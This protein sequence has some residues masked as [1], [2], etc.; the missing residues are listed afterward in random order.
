[1]FGWKIF[2]YALMKNHFH[3]VL[4]TVNPNLVEGM[5]WLQCTYCTRFNR[6]RSERGHVFQGRYYAGLIENAAVMSHI[7]DYVHLN[8]VRAEIVDADNAA[9]FRWSSLGRFVRG[10]RFPGLVANE[11]LEAKGLV[12][13]DNGWA[14][15]QTELKELAENLDKQKE[16]G[17]DGFSYGWAHG[18]ES[19]RRAVAKQHR[20]HALNPGLEA[21]QL[22]ELKAELWT[23]ALMEALQELGRTKEDLQTGLRGE[24]WKLLLAIKLREKHGVPIAWL[25]K[26][27][28]LGKESSARSQICR[29]KKQNQHATS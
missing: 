2:A 17:W 3:V 29:A 6:F 25:V 19:W 18:S 20:Q 7:V 22:N 16:L 13:N 27:L 5:H 28:K 21:S 1:M 8:P 15:Y 23:E 12:D 11:W 14:A 9:S 24:R 10:A 26:E 4:E